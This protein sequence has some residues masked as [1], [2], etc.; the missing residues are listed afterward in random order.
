MHETYISTRGHKAK[1][2]FI[3]VYYF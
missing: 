2:S 1:Q 3:Q